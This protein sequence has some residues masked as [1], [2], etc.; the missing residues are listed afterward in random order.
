M[1]ITRIVAAD[2]YMEGTDEVLVP[3]GTILTVVKCELDDTYY[4]GVAV[5]VEFDG[6]KAVIN[7]AYLEMIEDEY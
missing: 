4:S 2:I 1:S 3:N 7:A 5:T 6:K